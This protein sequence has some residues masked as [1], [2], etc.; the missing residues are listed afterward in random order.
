MVGVKACHLEVMG[1]PFLPIGGLP[2]YR[3]RPLI[4]LL[5]FTNLNWE[6]GPMINE[7]L[8]YLS[9]EVRG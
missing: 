8:F 9:F 3:A 1:L 6:Y 5:A 4:E 7:A 2:V